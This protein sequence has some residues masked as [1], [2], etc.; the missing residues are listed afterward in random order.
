[1]GQRHHRRI[2][3]RPPHL[4]IDGKELEGTRPAGAKHALNQLVSVWVSQAQLTLAQRQIGTKE[5]EIVAIPEVLKLI[6]I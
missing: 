6:Y 3:L 4:S 1:V 2:T 5:N